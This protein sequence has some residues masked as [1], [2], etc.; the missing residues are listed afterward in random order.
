MKTLWQDLVY[1]V[2]VFRK[3]P[4]FTVTATLALAVVIGASC[5][6][7]SLLDAAMLRPLPF[8]D[9][10]Q[11]VALWERPP[12]FPKNS[13]APLN[14]LDWRDQNKSFQS[15]AGLAWGQSHDLRY[16]RCAGAGRGPVGDALVFRT[17]GRKPQRRPH[18][19]RQ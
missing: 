10:H 4:G 15:M 13:V 5:A 3:A 8:R 6:I 19:R 18:V 1:A 14:Y 16:E 12:Q 9:A 11:L 17:A 2:R 7:F